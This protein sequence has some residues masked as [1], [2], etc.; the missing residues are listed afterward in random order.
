MF[1]SDAQCR[2]LINQTPTSVW[3]QRVNT[4]LN[5]TK[6]LRF[7]RGGRLPL[8][9]WPAMDP[10]ELDV[11]TADYLVKELDRRG[12]GLICSWSPEKREETL[13][14]ALVI[15]RAQK[16]LG[17]RINVNANE[18]LHHFFNGDELTAHIDNNGKP[19]FDYSFGE[20][21]K[22]G[23]PFTLDIRKDAIR[24]Q[25]EYF[26]KV[27]KAEGLS[28]DF[29]FADWE[30]DGP[31]EVNGAW[32]ASK[33]CTR[34]RAHIKNIDDFMEFQKMMREMRSYLQY[35]VFSEPVLSQFPDALVG[36]YALYPHDGYRYWYDYFEYYADGHPYKGDQR[37]KHRKWYNDFPMTGYTFAMPVV[38]SLHMSVS[39]FDFDNPDYRWFYNLL[40]QVSSVGKNTPI[41]IPIISFVNGASRN[42]DNSKDFTK[43]KEEHYRELL[44]HMLLRGVDTLFMWCGKADDAYETRVVHEVYAEAQ[45]Y[46][47]FIEKGVPISF[48]VPRKPGTVVSGLMLGDRVLIRRT[49]FGDS[50][51]P[52][53]I[54]AGTKTLSIPY[55]PGA[56]QIISLK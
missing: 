48:E 42:K 4:V 41:S 19:F 16:K 43:F 18:C 21:H 33:N 44:W 46:G 14:R 6:P 28:V 7:D 2:D 3:S 17:L 1:Y 52:V 24:E 23:C 39:W 10:G 20:K 32:E 9:L 54:L 12:I 8:Y 26:V 11:A 38:Y 30:I 29:I 49:D 25:V 31:L 15:A 55:K 36:N 13:G 37:A 50:H 56:C 5:N 47:E 34:C 40:L 35:Y 51:E 53:R 45:E 22:M 27:Y